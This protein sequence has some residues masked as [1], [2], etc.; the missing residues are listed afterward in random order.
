MAR[1]KEPR[2]YQRTAINRAVAG[3]LAG[4]KRQLLVMATGT[5]KTFV[6]MQIVWKLQRAAG[7]PAATLGCSTSPTATSSSISHAIAS[8]C[9][10]SATTRSTSS[11]GET[12]TGSGHLLRALPEPR[13]GRGR[14]VPPVPRRLLRPDHRRRVPPRLVDRLSR[15][16]AT[17]LELLRAGDPAR[18]D[19]HACT[20]RGRRHVPLLRR[21]DLRVLAGPRHRRRLPR[22]LHRAAR[23][24]ERRCVRVAPG[25]GPAR[26]VRQRDPRMGCTRFRSSSASSPCSPVRRRPRLTSPST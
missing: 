7:E 26:H 5:G 17:I 13:L 23:G 6:A 2:Y 18:P 24:A 25:P 22:P 16:G 21:A 19:R 4:D 14:L 15:P 9:R 11:P 10:S 1:S 20:G 3:V 12:K 8:S